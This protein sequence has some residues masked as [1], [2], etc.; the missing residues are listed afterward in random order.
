[1]KKLF[2]CASLLSLLTL[3]SCG[4]PYA[5]PESTVKRFLS[6]CKQGDKRAFMDCVEIQDRILLEDLISKGQGDE[7]MHRIDGK[8]S[9]GSTEITGVRSTVQVTL[10][11]SGN[12]KHDVINL[13][14][15]RDTW[16]IDLIPSELEPVLRDMMNGVGKST[17][18][19]M[20]APME[21]ALRA[22]ESALQS[23][24]AAQR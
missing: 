6:A 16:R 23:Q 8:F 15:V 7:L 17:E 1:M 3:I 13:I 20:R 22:M 21:Q 11:V 24:P 10:E 4:G 14:K 9:L 18:N 12:R 19:Q 5:S 2:A